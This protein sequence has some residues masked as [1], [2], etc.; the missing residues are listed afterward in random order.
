MSECGPASASAAEA[1]AAGATA[2][3]SAASVQNISVRVAA[4]S[5]WVRVMLETNQLLRSQ[6]SGG[7]GCYCIVQCPSSEDDFLI[8]FRYKDWQ[9]SIYMYRSTEGLYGEDENGDR[10]KHNTWPT[11]TEFLSNCKRYL[12]L[13]P[14]RFSLVTF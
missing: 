1:C 12:G 7:H 6:S 9:G 8:K 2:D 5:D 11:V 13:H 4:W 14:E 10:D 3:D